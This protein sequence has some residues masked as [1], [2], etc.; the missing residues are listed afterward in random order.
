MPDLEVSVITPTHRREDF[1]VETIE[2]VL[3]QKGVSL[4]LIVLDDTPEGSAQRAVES[5][6][7]ARVSYHKRSTPSGGRPAVARNEGLARA[8]GRYVYFLDDD[9]HVLPGALAALV[10]ALDR[11]P[12]AAVAYGSVEPF[13][14]DEAIVERYRRWFAWARRVSV[15]LA[16]SSWLT[17]GFIL[18]RGTV[19]INS[20]CMMRRES[21]LALRGYDTSIPLYEDV[22]FHMRGIRRFGHV[23]V[24]VPVL[25]YRTGSP[26]LIHDL[27]GDVGPIHRSNALIHGKYRR[28]YGALDYRALQV[29][30]RLLPLEGAPQT[31][32][33]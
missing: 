2:S 3:S 10:G 5:V 28:T 4:E 30:T 9:D 29:A 12:K 15:P 25:H 1:V 26:S 18:F 13:G 24:D 33:R 31:G 22:E 17:T 19:I 11:H 20:A 7:D 8:T 32:G 21:A 23:F 6:Q 16:R 14:L 27:L